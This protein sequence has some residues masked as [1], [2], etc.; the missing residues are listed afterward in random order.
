MFICF[1]RRHQLQWNDSASNDTFLQQHSTVLDHTSSP[2]KSFTTGRHSPSP[3]HFSSDISTKL[4]Q[5]TPLRH[6]STT[7]IHNMSLQ[8]VCPACQKKASVHYLSTAL[9]L[10]NFSLQLASKTSIWCEASATFHARRYFQSRAPATQD[11]RKAL[12]LRV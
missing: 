1:R 11:G 6:I 9:Q 2:Q 12:T 5:N 7:L 10:L 3:Q 4:I 8:R